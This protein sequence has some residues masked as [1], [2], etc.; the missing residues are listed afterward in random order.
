[1]DERA[2]ASGQVRVARLEAILPDGAP[3]SAGDG[4]DDVVPPRPFEAQFP[5]QMAGLDVFVAVPERSLTGANLATDPSAPTGARFSRAEAAVA[6]ENTGFGEQA[7]AWS[8]KNL[9]IL[10]EGE[11]LDGFTTLRVARLARSSTGAVI[12][13]PAFVPPVLAVRASPV[14]VRGFRRLLAAMTSRQRALTGS[15]RQRSEAQVDFEASDAAKFWLLSC[16]NGTIP[17][18]AHIV[19]QGLMDPERAYLALAQLT[20]QLSTFAV[21]GDV[22]A[23]PRF[24]F[25]DLGSTFVP[26]FARALE[27]VESVIAER[28][29]EIPLDR[30]E[31][32]LYVGTLRDPAVLRYEMFLVV[33]PRT[34]SLSDA[35]VRDRVPK[36]AKMASLSQI[37]SI[38]NSA[39][40]GV[41]LELEYRPPGALPIKPDMIFFHV[42]RTPDFW[43]DIVATGT[44]AL[45][46][47]HEPDQVSV[48]L[49][50]V[51]PAN[52]K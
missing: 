35:Q 21:Q 12:L 28:Y 7:L 17:L 8:R 27:L 30:R 41:R 44:L 22:T 1:M 47:P 48:A 36:L 39:V 19:D 52:L 14:L 34:A 31:D 18:F 50:A 40:P 2:L 15:R 32:R 25:L 24:A 4:L 38:L 16:L 33:T 3:V 20:G 10:F 49:Y 5:A 13:D 43:N 9:R 29:V 6:D 42:S 37:P 26:L 11:R 23:I 46:L 51:D 45:Y